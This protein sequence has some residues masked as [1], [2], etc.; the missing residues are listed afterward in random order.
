[1]FC[2]CR[3][4]PLACFTRR[5][6]P[7]PPIPSPCSPVARRT[8][9][10]TWRPT[11][12]PT[13]SMTSWRCVACACAHRSS[14]PSLCSLEAPAVTALQSQHRPRLVR[15]PSF[16][17]PLQEIF[18]SVLFNKPAEP[19]T[20]IQSE[21]TRMLAQKQGAKP[22]S[23]A[24]SRVYRHFLLLLALLPPTLSRCSSPSPRLSFLYSFPSAD[25]AVRRV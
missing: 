8:R 13:R 1:M 24:A 20:F 7:F 16:P 21:A 3:R 2:S 6:A 4:L 23:A 10:Q 14:S 12:P 17:A 15:L 19:A 25:H 22:V 11:C 9:R 5:G 18:A